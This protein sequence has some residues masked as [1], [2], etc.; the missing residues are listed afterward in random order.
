M[1]KLLN[2]K[3]LATIAVLAI[4]GTMI[5]LPSL[6]EDSDYESLNVASIEAQILEDNITIKRAEIAL[7]LAKDELEEAEDSKGDFGGSTYGQAMNRRYYVK[8]A[9][10]DLYVAEKTLEASQ[11]SEVLSGVEMYYDYLLLVK[12]IDLQNSQILRLNEELVGVEK[13]IELG[14]ATINERTIK[15]LEIFNAEFEL[16]QLQDEKETLFLDM[17]LALQQDLSTV[18]VIEDIDIPFEVYTQDDDLAEH[19]EY[20][21]V[22]N[23]DLWELEI[24]DELDIIQLD[25]YEDNNKRDVY[26]SEINAL[27]STIKQNILD[28]ENKKLSLEYN[29]RS[30]YNAIL[31]GYDTVMIKGLE[32][33]N[34]N[35]TL[36]TLTKRFEVGYET[37]N[38]VK[39]AQENVDRGAL[40]V[41][42][43]KLDYYV[44]IETYENFIN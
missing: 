9:E 42:Q 35:L 24:Q 44:A 29:L 27:K 34:L 31:N 22:T 5:A 37:E 39:V 16:L 32:L 15:E 17:N 26:D 7:E 28:I 14:S 36:T 21:L 2:K 19:L 23:M 43:A 40:E 41:L 12:E 25:I 33:D 3:S 6:G 4:A 38:T 20:I 1:M 10:M 8:A 13:K 30:Y 11:Q 18:L